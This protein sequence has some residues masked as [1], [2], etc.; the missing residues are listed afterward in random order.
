MRIQSRSV[1]SNHFISVWR[2]LHCKVEAWGLL[3]GVAV[4]APSF[5][6]GALGGMFPGRQR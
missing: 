3:I 2:Q 4:V 6:L 1:D 5:M